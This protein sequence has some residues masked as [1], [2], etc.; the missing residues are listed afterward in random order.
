M[1]GYIGPNGQTSNTYVDWVP[2]KTVYP[3][4]ESSVIFHDGI[5]G[6]VFD[7]TYNEYKFEFVNIHPSVNSTILSFQVNAV[8]QSGFDET[9]TSSTFEAEHDE[10]G[11]AA[12]L[13]YRTN[14]DQDQDAGNQQLGEYI[15]NDSNS[16]GIGEL[17]FYSPSSTTYVKHWQS[18]FNAHG[19]SVPQVSYHAGYINTTAAIDEV[20]FLMTANDMSASGN[21]DEGTITL[22]GLAK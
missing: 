7:N 20:K 13:Q 18:K 15:Y 5:N 8:G 1:A 12:A 6:V 4:G 9:I 22:Y 19:N 2:I 17:I 16:S 10:A 11:S 21:I 3:R 14:R